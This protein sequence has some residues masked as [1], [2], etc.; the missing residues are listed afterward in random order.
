MKLNLFDLL[1]ESLAL[2]AGQPTTSDVHYPKPTPPPP[3]SPSP[4]PASLLTSGMQIKMKAA[5]K[6]EDGEIV[7]VDAWGCVRP[8]FGNRIS[9]AVPI[10]LVIRGADAGG[11]A[12]VAING[13][14][15]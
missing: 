12:I 2:Y 6:V 10:G 13:V 15:E 11:S 9:S 1:G 4:F 14:W 7:F 8:S 5:E 3:P